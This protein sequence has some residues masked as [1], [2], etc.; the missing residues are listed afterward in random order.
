MC[1]YGIFTCV[2][3]CQLHAYGSLETTEGHQ[4]SS[5]TLAYDFERAA[6]LD[7][8]ALSFQL[9][10]K[11]EN[12]GGLLVSVPLGAGF[13]GICRLLGLLLWCWHLNFCPHA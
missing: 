6:F 1:K 11:P 7:P 4:V 9:G 3:I 13:T 12:P 5:I 2:F 10:W 8:A